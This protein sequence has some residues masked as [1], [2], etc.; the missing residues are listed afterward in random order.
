MN[1]EDAKLILT[2]AISFI[3]ASTQNNIA[4]LCSMR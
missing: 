4:R 3:F 1:N 2:I